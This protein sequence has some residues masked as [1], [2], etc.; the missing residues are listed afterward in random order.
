MTREDIARAY[1]VGTNHP[2]LVTEV[3]RMSQGYYCVAGWDIHEERMMRPLGL[4]R[5]N[6]RIGAD[7]SVFK[8]GNLIDCAPSGIRTTVA[9][10]SLDDTPL[11]STPSILQAFEEADTYALVL[12]TTHTSVRGAFGRALHDDK[13]VEEGTECHSLAGVR[14]RRDQLRFHEDYGKLRVSMRDSDRVSYDLKVTCDQLQHFFSPGD[15]DAEPHFGVTEAN[16]WLSV[17]DPAATIILRLGFARPWDGKD[18]GWSPRRCY[19][20][21]NGLLCPTDNYHMFAGRPA[22]PE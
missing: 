1:P 20:Q 11:R 17:N 21:L 18:K 13:Y 7:R 2:V 9:P 3:T 19:L 12:D 6:W 16:E 8:V 14:A 4:D 10:H 22:G 5:S 15:A